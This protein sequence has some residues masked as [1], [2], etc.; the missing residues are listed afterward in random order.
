MRGCDLISSNLV[1]PFKVTLNNEGSEPV[2]REHV[3]TMRW[4]A[5]REDKDGNTFAAEFEMTKVK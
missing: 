1:T 3:D 2:V 4:V 5:L